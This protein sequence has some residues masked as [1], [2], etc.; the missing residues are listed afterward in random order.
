MPRTSAVSR[1]T[2]AK[3]RRATRKTGPAERADS[4]LTYT[5]PPVPIDFAAG[6]HRFYRAD[7]EIRG[8]YHGEASY[9][10]RIF[11]NNPAANEDTAKTTEN[12]YAGSF[13]IFGH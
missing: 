1:R 13:Y 7:L 2:V 5:S 4:P 3:K 9:E 11:F 6:P 12:G 8:I 10:G